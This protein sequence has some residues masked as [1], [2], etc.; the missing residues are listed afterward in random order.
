MLS[1]GLWNYTSEITSTFP[2]GQQTIFGRW[3]NAWTAASLVVLIW[4][5]FNEGYYGRASM[6]KCHRY[7]ICQP[8]ILSLASHSSAHVHKMPT[9]AVAMAA[10]PSFSSNLDSILVKANHHN[11][12]RSFS[13]SFFP[14]FSP[15]LSPG[16]QV[17]V[18]VF[19]ALFLSVLVSVFL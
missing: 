18:N 13:F 15:L 1:F 10:T 14:L 6:S 12:P 19:L 11:P 8:V 17:L 16:A 2:V 4:H 5:Q 9:W 3:G 7:S